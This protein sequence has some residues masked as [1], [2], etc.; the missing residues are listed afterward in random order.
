MIK[1]LISNL[2]GSVL[3]TAVNILAVP[4]YITYLG[5]ESYGLIGF[6]TTLNSVFSIFDMGL[7]ATMVREM[8]R[9]SA[10]NDSG[11]S[12]RDL[13]RTFEVIFWAVTIA[14]GC[15]I[16]AFSSFI[17]SHWITNTS[18]SPDVVSK[19]VMLMGVSLIFH[20]PTSLYAG[21]LTGLQRQVTLNIINGITELCKL[22]LVLTAFHFKGASIANFFYSQIIALTISTVT[23]AVVYWNYLPAGYVRARFQKQ[24]F[25]RVWRFSAGMG[26]LSIVGVILGQMDK[27]LLIKILSLKQYS[28]YVLA[29]TVVA[30]LYK[31]ITPIFQT[32]YPKMV[33]MVSAK[34]PALPGKYHNYA[35]LMLVVVAPV[36][37][38]IG[39]FPKEIILFWTQNQL[40]STEAG[41][42]ASILIIG[43]A[44]QGVM[45]IPYALQLAN[46]IT[47]L[48]FYVNLISLVVLAPLLFLFVNLFG[49]EGGA[50]VW[51]I[52]NMGYI[53]ITVPLMHRTLLK[54]EMWNWYWFDFI[55]PGAIVGA[56]AYI[57]HFMVPAAMLTNSYKTFF[58]I[59][60]FT[61]LLYIVSAGASSFTRNII[62]RKVKHLFQT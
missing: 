42:I 10:S 39:F 22:L 2:F 35:Q 51:V 33:Q 57:L 16:I 17:S 21:G 43:T 49:T 36:A 15:L 45:F 34:D 59:G 28:Y 47:S 41:P 9:L 30:L 6:Y 19:A 52:L 37:L 62:M 53:L 13:A 54:A 25:L 11:Q 8:A 44:F 50:M 27:L 3:I 56:A 38:T 61:C 18:L 48:S 31:V 40:L 7:S 5:S 58:L 29:G 32:V 24:E 26:M 20:L 4:I 55:K 23:T 46:G 14:L 12:M 1:N 60:S